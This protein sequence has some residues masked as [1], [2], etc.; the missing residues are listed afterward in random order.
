MKLWR[1]Y[2][3]PPL[4]A[5]KHADQAHPGH[6]LDIQA[7]VADGFSHGMEAGFREG[8]EAGE[9]AGREAGYAVGLE[10]GRR[11]GSAH[12]REEVLAR[13]EDLAHPLEA[14]TAALHRLC[15]EYHGVLRDELVVL[16][17]KVARQVIRCELTLKPTQILDLIDE[18]LATLPPVSADVDIH[19]NSE[20][21]ER[22]R[23]L[24]PERVARWHFVPDASLPL[25]ECRIRTPESEIDAGC[26]QRLE[27]CLV[28]VREQLNEVSPPHE[29]PTA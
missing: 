25:G 14:A 8:Y 7:S 22:I 27:A 3:F 2:R 15:D 13:F 4:V 5:A 16:V 12:G 9:K 17:A 28:K 24:A 6:S 23:E 1:P 20:E 21:Y 11:E 19:L 10:S 29:P 26:A 18:T